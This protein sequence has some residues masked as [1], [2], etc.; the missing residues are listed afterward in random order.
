[1]KKLILIAFL[2]T[3]CHREPQEIKDSILKLESEE[4]IVRQNVDRLNLLNSELLNKLEKLKNDSEVLDAIKD[5][6]KVNY[7]IKIKG[8]Q[9]RFSLDIGEHIKDAANAFDFEIPVSK[10]FYDAH[11]VGDKISESFRGGSLIL[12]G[13]IG[14]MNLTVIEK[15]IVVN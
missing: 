9:S 8:Q 14:S 7:I 4:K 2:V 5:G 6:R 13:S 3:S 11:E 12:R 10:E 15:R 1:M